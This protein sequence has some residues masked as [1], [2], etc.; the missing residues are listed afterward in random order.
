MRNKLVILHYD[1]NIPVTEAQSWKRVLV[2]RPQGI[3]SDAAELFSGYQR[4]FHCC[5][6]EAEKREKCFLCVSVSLW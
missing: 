5:D 3:M 6:A 4:R 2:S 1:F